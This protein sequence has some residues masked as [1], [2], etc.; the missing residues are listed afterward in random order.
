[1]FIYCGYASGVNFS[2]YFFFFT[3]FP[4]ILN[5]FQ[6]KTLQTSHLAQRRIPFNRMLTQL[7]N[8]VVITLNWIPWFNADRSQSE[9]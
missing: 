1:M 9:A 5:A 4:V 2:F 6:W 3:I 8:S 7:L